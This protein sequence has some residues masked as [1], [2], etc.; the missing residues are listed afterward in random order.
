[1]TQLFIVVPTRGE[2]ATLAPLVDTLRTAVPSATILLAVNG[3]AASPSIPGDVEVV[4]VPEGYSSSR[5]AAGEI[6][7]RRG[8]EAILFV[9]DDV[10]TS[11]RD[12]ERFISFAQ[13]GVRSVSGMKVEKR[14]DTAYSDLASLVLLPMRREDEVNSLPAT[15]LYVPAELFERT[16]FAVALDHTGAEDTVFTRDA[17]A[18]GYKLR[19]WTDGDSFE[20]H[21][22]DRTTAVSLIGRMLAAKSAQFAHKSSRIRA[23][24]WQVRETWLSLG[25]TISML[26]ILSR[27]NP[28]AAVLAVSALSR[29]MGRFGFTI[30]RKEGKW[31][32]VIRVR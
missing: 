9:D 2:R 24:D 3:G 21:P 26:A 17:L 10:V 29:V 4:G 16:R 28:R 11:V 7:L 30:A 23:S 19:L 27:L 8:A 12:V 15:F 25:P 13:H 18:D 14:F 1:V 32:S 6:A 22:A 31:S 20:Y 5:N